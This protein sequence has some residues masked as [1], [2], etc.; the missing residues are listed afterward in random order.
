MQVSKLIEELKLC[1]D[2]ACVVFWTDKYGYE[3]VKSLKST[4][5]SNILPGSFIREYVEL[6]TE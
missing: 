4:T 3:P 6:K 2:D 5:D 1:P